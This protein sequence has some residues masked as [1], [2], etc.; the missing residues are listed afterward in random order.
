MNA[1]LQFLQDLAA[2]NDREW[3][4]ANKQRYQQA[5][6]KWNEFCLQLIH[7]MGQYDPEDVLRR[8]DPPRRLCS[9]AICS[10]RV[11]CFRS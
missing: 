1:I 2:H 8:R 11:W 7:E 3:F 4:N 5:Q 9:K 10:R 6:S